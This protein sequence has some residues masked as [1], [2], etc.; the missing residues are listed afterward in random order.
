MKGSDQRIIIPWIVSIV[1]SVVMAASVLLPYGA[2]KD[3]ESLSAMSELIGEDLV[4]PSMAKFAQVYMAH[5]GEYINELQAYI[6]LGIT[7]AIAVFSLLALLFAV[8]KKPIATIVFAILALLVF[9]AQSFDFS[10][11]GVVPSDN[12]GWGI[13]YYALFA[14]IIV[15]IV[16]AIWMFAAHRQAKKMQA[17]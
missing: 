10:N 14:G 12:Y 9:L 1:G 7:T 2:A 8:L 6:T 13:G 11:R 5:A 3:A 4:N 15:T 16:G 17:V